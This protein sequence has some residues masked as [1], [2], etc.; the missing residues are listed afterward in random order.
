M[1]DGSGRTFGGKSLMPRRIVNILALLLV[2]G[3]ALYYGVKIRRA[4]YEA[5]EPIRF[6]LDLNNAYWW[7]K[8]ARSVG[9]PYLYHAVAVERRGFSASVQLDYTPLRLV[10]ATAWQVYI[11]KH[12][13]GITRI[14]PEFEFAAPMLWGNT[15][16]GLVASV[17]VFLNIRLWRGRHAERWRKTLPLTPA[18]SPEY[19]GEG[20]N[21]RRVLR[22][23]ED[24]DRGARHP[25]PRRNQLHGAW[26]AMLG[27]LLMWFNPALLWDGYVW[28]QWD[29]WLVPFA[30]AAIYF[31]SINGW[32]VA[33]ACLAIG[34]SL[35]GQ[36][37]MAA[38]IFVVWPLF[39]LRFDALLRLVA[40]FAL[41]TAWTIFPFL[42]P[43]RAGLVW[44]MLTIGAMFLLAPFVLR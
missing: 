33:G 41:I 36:L 7:G 2:A 1:W 21:P 12:Y 31:A 30:V 19:E 34:A 8:N 39:Q 27:A 14:Q 40:G 26:P 38:P 32:F 3:S 23:A 17:F 9:L 24:P 42:L 4:I 44:Y 10:A 11:E 29:V 35:K 28:P 37:L 5:S 22:Y 16:A 6:T 13:P 20:A 25:D 43:G 18:L 15:L